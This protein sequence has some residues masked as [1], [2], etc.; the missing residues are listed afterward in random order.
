MVQ[1]IENNLGIT[2][3]KHISDIL[4]IPWPFVISKFHCSLTTLSGKSGPCQLEKEK[5]SRYVY[6]RTQVLSSSHTCLPVV[7]TLDSAIQR[8][9]HYPADS[10]TDFR[11]TYRLDSDL[12]GG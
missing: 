3:T 7:Q 9:N 12:S 11:N 5:I 8:I 4:P 6:F 2:Y 10:V 1:Y